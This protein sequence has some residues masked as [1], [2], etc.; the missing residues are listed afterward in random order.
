MKKII[1]LALAAAVFATACQK[2]DHAEGQKV[3]YYA[4]IDLQGDN[5]YIASVGGNYTDPGY[6]A[7]LNGEDATDRVTLDSNVD[8]NTM[9]LYSVKYTVVNDDGFSSS[10]SRTVIVANPGHIDTVYDSYSAYGTR[11]YHNPMALTEVSAGVYAIDDIMGGFYCLGR[12][13]GYEAYGYDFWGEGTFKIN[14]DNSLTLLSVGP[15]YFGGSFD[16]TSFE[17]AYDPETGVIAWT[18]EGNFY[19]TLTPYS[20]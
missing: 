10:E 19:V 18:I 9:G 20:N 3:T 14:D 1:I 5:P 8:M 2:I 13:P 7:T 11:K 12:Y 4:I 15:W 6:T 17:G 16:Y